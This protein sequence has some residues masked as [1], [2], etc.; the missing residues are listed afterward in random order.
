MPSS[1]PASLL[2]RRMAV[3]IGSGSLVAA[4]AL[5]ERRSAEAHSL[6]IQE[7]NKALVRR[8]F[9]EAVNGGNDAVIAEL[10]A[11]ELVKRGKP[12]PQMPGPAG[13]PLPIVHF[14][15]LYPDI[16]VTVE[17]TIAEDDFVASR[18]IWRDTYPPADEHTVGRTMHMFRI[19]NGQIVEQWSTGW[20]WLIYR[21]CWSEPPPANPLGE[22]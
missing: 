19:T 10:Y 7:A 13:M 17:S 1:S 5:H 12:A 8:V 20:E 2:N 14:H 15:A 4:V 11:P 18:A 6:T 3:R 16:S 22:T 21:D 9:E